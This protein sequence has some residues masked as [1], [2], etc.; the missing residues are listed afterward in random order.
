[1]WSLVIHAG[2]GDNGSPEV[3]EALNIIAFH[4]SE[5][6]DN[7][8]NASEV[9][10][11]IISSMENSILFN[12]GIS[13][14]ARTSDNKI[15]LDASIMKSNLEYGSI[16]G[17][18]VNHPIA[19]ANKLMNGLKG[20]FYN[21]YSIDGDGS[22]LKGSSTTTESKISYHDTVGCVVRDTFGNLCS[23][24]STGG[25]TGKPSHR[26]GDSPMIG[27]GV[28]ANDIVAVTVS[29]I[30][31]SLIPH[32]VSFHVWALMKYN[33]MSVQQALDHIIDKVLPKNCGGIVAIDSNGTIA[34][35]YNTLTFQTVACTSYDPKLM[36]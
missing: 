32:V 17:T 34:K 35:A 5:L 29:G 16:I 28:Y 6:L 24:S 1:M 7:K 33:N 11:F 21:F 27:H 3:Q 15:E 10:V 25:L 9:V 19:L 8:I 20:N 12:A 30:G 2:A 23:G 31:E 36:L 4:A 13:G 26:F 18:S 22:P 14:S